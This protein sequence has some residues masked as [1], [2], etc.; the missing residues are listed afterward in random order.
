MIET[1]SVIVVIAG[2]LGVRDSFSNQ[3]I[4]KDQSERVM[5][6]AALLGGFFGIYGN[7]SGFNMDGAIISVRDIGPMLA[8]FLGGPMSGFMAG[9]ICGIHRLLLGGITAPAC[10]TATCTIGL[11]CGLL[12]RYKREWIINPW[13]AFVTGAIAEAFHLCVVLAMVRPFATA[14]DIVT[15]IAIPFVLVN[16]VGYALMIFIVRITEDRKELALAQ[17][18]I[19]SELQVATV[20]QQSLLPPIT[21]TFPGRSEFQIQGTMTPAKEVG[22]DFYDFF[23][24]GSDKIALVIGDVSGKGIPAA[25]FMA[26]S[27]VTLQ[28]CVRDYPNLAEAVTEAN[29]MLCSRNEADMFVTVWVGVLDIPTG[30]LE[31]VSAGHNP[32]VL[33]SAGADTSPA[34]YLRSLNGLILGGIDGYPYHSTTAQ[35]NP[36]D[37][38]LLYTDGITEAINTAKE[39]YGEDRLQEVSAQLQDA[40][41]DATIE[42]IRNSIDDFVKDCDQSDDITMLCLQYNGQ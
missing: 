10:C 14:V 39:L 25:L 40:D 29:N 24:L 13:I 15:R 42:A 20:I 7:L 41:P 38:I 30:Q 27:K 11:C 34:T 32:P 33:I 17:S 4:D 36:G 6:F 31:Y 12:A 8:G 37:K 22:G 16:S 21:D 9:A 3:I 23:F 18:R 1:L 19:Q 26:T 28:N 2:F 5:I 35:I